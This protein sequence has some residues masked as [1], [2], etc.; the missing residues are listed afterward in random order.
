VNDSGCLGGDSASV[1]SFIAFPFALLTYAAIR[2]LD[3]P[4]QPNKQPS[5]TEA[6]YLE[7]QSANYCN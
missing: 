3:L 1:T 5:N 7:E 6:F 4:K 2:T